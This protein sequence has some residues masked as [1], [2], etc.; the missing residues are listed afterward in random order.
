MEVK[1]KFGANVLIKWSVTINKIT[2]RIYLLTLCDENDMS[3]L[4]KLTKLTTSVS[5]VHHIR[6]AQSEGRAYK[7]I[8]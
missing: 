7:M 8:V 5:P 1:N 3:L 4:Y 2:D 6:Q